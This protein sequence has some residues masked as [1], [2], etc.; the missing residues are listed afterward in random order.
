MSMG[1][2]ASALRFGDAQ[3]EVAG[4]ECRSADDQIRAILGEQT[5]ASLCGIRMK[6]ENSYTN[7]PRNLIEILDC[8]YLG[9][10][11]DLIKSNSSW[12]L[13]K[14]MFRDKRELEDLLKDVMPVRNDCAHF[15]SVPDRE[16]NRCRLRCEDLMAIISKRDRSV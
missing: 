6:S 4:H 8:A 2:R 3:G 16:M 15:R 7:T 10:L 1:Q 5:W 12:T 13:F 9:Q 11:G 14:S